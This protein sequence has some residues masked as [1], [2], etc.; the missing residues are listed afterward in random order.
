MSDEGAIDGVVPL[1]E[2]GSEHPVEDSGDEGDSEDADEPG[3]DGGVG[4]EEGVAVSLVDFEDFGV[5]FGVVVETES[6]SAARGEEV[7]AFAAH[8]GADAAADARHQGE[9]DVDD[10]GAQEA[11][12]PDGDNGGEVGSDEEEGIDGVGFGE[13]PPATTEP[14]D[15]ECGGC[16]DGKECDGEVVGAVVAVD[17][18]AAEDA[19]GEGAF[20]GEG[21]EGESDDEEGYSAGAGDE[22]ADGTGAEDEDPAEDVF[23]DEPGV[24]VEAPAGLLGGRSWTGVAHRGR[25]LQEWVRAMVV[26]D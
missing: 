5:G 23:D 16:E 7:E 8:P 22:G 10:V 1:L 15:D 21:D 2:D 14:G 13:G 26:C 20:A 3:F 11:E 24:V 4:I 12:A 6:E 19:S 25:V 9:E 17:G 18:D